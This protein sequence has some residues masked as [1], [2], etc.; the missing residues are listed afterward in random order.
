MT[1]EEK[2]LGKWLSAALDD[3]HSC[4]EFKEDIVNWF[5]SKTITTKEV[6]HSRMKI[7]RDMWKSLQEEIIN[8]N[9]K[10]HLN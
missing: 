4:E 6:T 7:E 3:P 2:E 1:K 9:S 10:Y 8:E 5:N